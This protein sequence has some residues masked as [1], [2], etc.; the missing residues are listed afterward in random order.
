VAEGHVVVSI[1]SICGL[2]DEA[3]KVEIERL[4]AELGD[5]LLVVE[6]DC[7]GL[8]EIAPAIVVNRRS[9]APANPAKLRAV[10]EASI[11]KMG[12]ELF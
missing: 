6:G 11:K 5:K 1:C 8:C 3:I 4:K 12:T 9:I 7:L 2:Q 10:V